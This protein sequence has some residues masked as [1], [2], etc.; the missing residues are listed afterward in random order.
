MKKR[1]PSI[2]P[3][4]YTDSLN[5]FVFNEV[6][7]NSSVMDVGCWNGGLGKKL[8]QDKHCEFN[9]IDFKKSVLRDA[10]RN[11][12]K[13]TFL[14]DLNSSPEKIKKISKKYD[15]IICADILE[16]LIDPQ[17]VLS[18]LSMLLNKNGFIIISLP[19]VAF[20]LNRLNLFLGKW[21]YTE[22]GTL[23][24]THLRFFTESTLKTFVKESGLK[25]K[26]FRP[27]NQFGFLS[28]I[29]PIDQIFPN[30]LCY[31]FLVVASKA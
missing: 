19:N 4:D 18:L 30:L 2:I 28:R 25:I 14:I 11:G 9:G 31:Q 22:Y 20:G 13:K 5:P 16:H 24:K 17:R 27:Y 6:P 3:A 29:Y 26:K 12:Y 10:E 21:N 7:E 8:I 15:V 23:D 1:A